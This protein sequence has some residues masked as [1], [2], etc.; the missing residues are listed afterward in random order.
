MNDFIYFVDIDGDIRNI[1]LMNELKKRGFTAI[2]YSENI[3][4]A[5]FIDK[6]NV[7]IF[8]P[9]KQLTLQD[10]ERISD[11][12]IV[13]AF[14]ISSDVSDSFKRKG[15]K[16]INPFQSE[17][18]AQNNAIITAEGV[19]PIIINNTVKE[20]RQLNILICG[21]G[22]IGK[23]LAYKLKLLGANVMVITF[24]AEEEKCA[25]IFNNQ[26]YEDINLLNAVISSQNV[27]VNTVPSLIFNNE[28]ISKATN[29]ALVIDV[30]SAPGGVDETACRNN[31]IPYIKALGLP[32]KCAPCSAGEYL[33]DEIIKS[34]S[35]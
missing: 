27:I 24:S 33:F 34:L 28:I 23:A 26:K 29:C 20:L 10:C 21:Y 1:Y 15:V 17:V 4:I 5:S 22:K 12:A 35:K 32:A 14:K 16:F 6:Q 2:A 13:F 9:S 8:A 7:Y 19:L 18:F 3:E 25:I 11:S 31:G 30:A